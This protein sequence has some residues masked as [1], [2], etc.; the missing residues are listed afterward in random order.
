MR[1]GC[2]HVPTKKKKKKKKKKERERE[3]NK[4]FS[5]KLTSLFC[6]V[7][8]LSFHQSSMGSSNTYTRGSITTKTFKF[9][10]HTQKK[11]KCNVKNDKKNQKEFL[12]RLQVVKY[13]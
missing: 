13:T 11:L 1:N 12:K 9:K 5:K 7:D 4:I 2:I 8:Q 10:T 3:K 6:A